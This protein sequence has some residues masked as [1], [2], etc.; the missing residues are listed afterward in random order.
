MAF[1]MIARAAGVPDH[2]QFRDLRRTATV[3]LARSGCTEAEI[4]SY[5]GWSPTSVASMM[6][7]YRPVDVSMADH[8]L[9]KFEAY[10]SKQK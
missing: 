2:M 7:I 8:A 10:R 5:G 1:R 6:K 3:Q 9:I 4:A